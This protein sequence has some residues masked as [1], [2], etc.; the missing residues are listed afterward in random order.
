MRSIPASSGS[1]L[2]HAPR[3]QRRTLCAGAIGV[4]VDAR[5]AWADPPRGYTVRDQ[6]VLP[7]AGLF[8][9][10]VGRRSRLFDASG[11]LLARAGDDFA[12]VHPVRGVG[13]ASIII[14]LDGSVLEE[15]FRGRRSLRAEMFSRGWTPGSARL[16]LLA[17]RLR[18]EDA[19]RLAQDET[20]LEV[21]QAV[22]QAAA[23]PPPADDLRTVD[24]ARQIIHAHAAD[25]LSLPQVA[26]AAGVS[27]NYLTHA[28]RRTLGQP[29]HQ[30][31]LGLRLAR[32]LVELPHC[33]DLARLAL[34]LGFSSH[35]HFTTAFRQRYGLSPSAWRAGQRPS[36][37][38]RA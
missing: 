16:Q 25:R 12:D 19:D 4:A 24:R 27:A 10:R 38:C 33:E 6:I 22:I 34:D 31:Q 8:A 21:A 5:A 35:S 20:L 14:S 13:H 37:R 29:L 28:F 9:Y 26:A 2:P 17:H 32:S 7:Y 36:G 30:Y 23:A 18:R 1:G 15:V 11:V 3:S